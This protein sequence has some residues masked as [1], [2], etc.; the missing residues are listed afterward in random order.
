GSMISS[1]LFALPTVPK[2]KHFLRLEMELIESKPEKMKDT[3]TIV[4]HRNE[5]ITAK[6][7]K[8]IEGRWIKQTITVGGVDLDNTTIVAHRGLIAAEISFLNTEMSKGEAIRVAEALLQTPKA[9][10]TEPSKEAK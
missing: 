10:P 1:G 3:L 2:T 7:S 5:E 6:E 4:I 9:A 8:T